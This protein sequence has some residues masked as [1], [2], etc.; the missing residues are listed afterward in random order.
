M[1]TAWHVLQGQAALP[2]VRASMQVVG[3]G[4]GPSAPPIIMPS[5]TPAHNACDTCHTYR[6]ACLQS[7]V[8][9]KGVRTQRHSAA[10]QVRA[11]HA[12]R[13]Q[14]HGWCTTHVRGRHATTHSSTLQPSMQPWRCPP[15]HEGH[16]ARSGVALAMTAATAPC[17]RLPRRARPCTAAMQA[18]ALL[19]APAAPAS[20]QPSPQLQGLAGMLRASPPLAA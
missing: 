19:P 18:G 13:T 12:K 7:R 20:W 10:H 15:H 6:G 2:Q 17:Q 4:A 8:L 11:V 9:V 14:H 3:G 1:G 16:H 5:P